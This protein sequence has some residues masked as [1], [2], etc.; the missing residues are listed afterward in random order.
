MEEWKARVYDMYADSTARGGLDA[1]HRSHGATARRQFL[2][3]YRRLLPSDKAAPVLDIGCGSGGVLEALDSVGYTR[4]EG[5]DISPS[6]VDRATARGLTGVTLAPAVDYLRDRRGHYAMVTAFSVL[7][8]QTRA[9]LF[10][11]LDAIR[12]ALVPGGSL[13][14]VV[15]NAKGLFGAHVRFADITHELSFS[16]GSVS[17]ICCVTGFELVHVLEHGPLVHGVVSAT[18]WVA[19]QVVRS[20]LLAA[21]VA[22]GADWRWPVFTQ[23][24]VFVARK[25]A[26]PSSQS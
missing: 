23:D 26:S 17:Q 22:E 4:L 24:L 12:E 9:E 1:G 10:E 7:E 14:A 21:R 18:R 2:Q 8:H 25:P 19:W 13:I 11:L 16:P 6:Q 20:V 3:R 5:V 15:P